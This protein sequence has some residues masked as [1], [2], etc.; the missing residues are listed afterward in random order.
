LEQAVSSDSLMTNDSLLVKLTKYKLNLLTDQD[1]LRKLEGDVKRDP[2]KVSSLRNSI[3]EN[4][5]RI[6]AMEERVKSKYPAYLAIR[7]A[8][9]EL[10]IKSVQEIAKKKNAVV[11]EY[12]WGVEDVYA[13]GISSDAI[14]FKK[15]GSTYSLAKRIASFISFFKT[16]TYSGTPDDVR[17][18]QDDSY[19]LYEALAES[20]SALMKD[21]D[22]LIIIPDGVISQIPFETLA[23]S[24]QQGNVTYKSI[25]YMVRHYSIAYMFSSFYLAQPRVNVNS[26]KMLA[27]GFTG[28]LPVRSG[29]GKSGM[30]IAGTEE[31]LEALAKKFPNGQFL[32]GKDVTEFNFKHSAPTADI[33]HLAVHGQGNTEQSYSASLFFRDGDGKEDGELHWYELYGMR[34]KSIL[35]VLSS[36]ESGIGKSYKG[37]GMLS[38]A[39][40]FALAGSKNVVMGLW[41]V[42]DRVSVALMDDFYKNLKEGKTVD[43]ALTISKREYLE[44]G[45]DLTANPKIWGALVAYGNQDVIKTNKGSWLI[46]AAF[47][48]LAALL[49]AYRKKLFPRH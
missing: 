12:F 45:D 20:F 21:R 22:H 2:A 31:E 48:V 19:K 3:V 14:V 36:C 34:L 38:M 28:G 8:N 42:D 33:L 6:L 10:H 40:A 18:Y 15:I 35:T 11:L 9:K 29:E 27:F 47:A 4:D 41:K 17:R 23:Q 46:V 26:P 25:D 44:R 39:N 24:D 7:E 1:R 30:E 43:E 32:Y 16:H 13:V 5:K 37:E 49:V